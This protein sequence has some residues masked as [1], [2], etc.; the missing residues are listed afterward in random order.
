MN[1]LCISAILSIDLMKTNTVFHSYLEHKI[2]SCD[3]S[4]V[5]LKSIETV[6]L[7]R[8][9][10]YERKSLQWKILQSLFGIAHDDGHRSHGLANQ[11]TEGR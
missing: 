7:V 2:Q 10:F 1:F 11:V 3:L 4:V 6:I 9:F 8:D 5:D